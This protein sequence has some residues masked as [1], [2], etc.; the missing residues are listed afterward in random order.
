MTAFFFKQEVFKNDAHME[1]V[2]KKLLMICMWCNLLVIL[3]VPG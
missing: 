2:L 3:F 1:E